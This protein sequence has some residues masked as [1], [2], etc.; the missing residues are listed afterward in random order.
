MRKRAQGT[1][2]EPRQRG[3]GALPARIA[4]G[5]K[6]SYSGRASMATGMAVGERGAAAWVRLRR[7]ALELLERENLVHAAFSYRVVALDGPAGEV[8]HVGGEQLRAPR[9]VPPSGELTAIACC[10]CTVGPGLAA[11]VND[12]FSERGTVS[13]GLALDEVSN[14]ILLAAERRAFDR[15]LADV[16]RSGLSMAGELRPGDP[17]LDI[18]TQ[19]AV[20]RLAKAE[21]IGVTLTESNMMWPFKSTSQILGVGLNLPPAQWSRCD[22]CRS[23][24]RCG[25]SATLPSVVPAS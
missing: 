14:N 22:S 1:V 15:L 16:T 7:Q 11:R 8:L 25:F 10:V 24:G 18:D 3:P 4:R 12:L 13:L 21:K 19:P 20:L 17:G 23:L 6:V 5:F 2:G 9:L